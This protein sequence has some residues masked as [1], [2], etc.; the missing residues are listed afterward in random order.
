MRTLLFQCLAVAAAF[1]FAALALAVARTLSGPGRVQRSAWI[2]VG[3]AFAWKAVVSLLHTV[4]ALW[5]LASGPGSRPYELMVRWGPVANHGRMLI[6]LAAGCGLVLLPLARSVSPARLWRLGTLVPPV[7]LALGVYAAWR[8][9]GTT[10]AHLTSMAVLNSVE[11]LLLLAA[12]LVGLFLYTLDRHLWICLAVYAF[13]VALNVVWTTALTWY[14]VPGSWYPPPYAMFF[15]VIGAYLVMM[16]FA[17]RRLS[18]AR[19][20][21]PVPALLEP[22]PDERFS[23]L[24]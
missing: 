24:A 8:E 14:F 20:G 22:L 1:G 4:P 21:T 16:V 3:T 10:A 17:R 5:A 15:H 6:G 11:L 18:L 23:S 7:L 2:I 19:S 13:H 9:G 12:L